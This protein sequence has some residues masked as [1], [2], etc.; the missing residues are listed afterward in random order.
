MAL[1]TGGDAIQAVY[2]IA[3]LNS[4]V[5]AG[6]LWRHRDRPGAAPLLANVL[7]AAVW[8]GTGL[9][10]M[11]L[12]SGPLARALFALM[13]LGIGFAT[14]TLLVFTLEYT[15][16]ER[17]TRP[18]ILAA[19]SIEPLL[20]ALFVVVNPDALF[21]TLH[22]GV[23]E[24]GPAFWI[25]TAYS[26][27]VLA[28]ATGL[29]GEFLYR[30]RSLYRGQS[31]ALLAGTVAA[32]VANG[33]YT[34]GP[35][36][37]DTTPIGFIAT[38][39]LYAIAIVRYRLTD[40]VPIA[41]DRVLDSV[42]DGVFVVDDDNRLIDANPVARSLLA[43][44]DGS[45]IGAT[46]DSL[47]ADW[48]ALCEEFRT[49]TAAGEPAE[50]ELEVDGEHYLVKTTPI[51][52]GRDRHVGWLFVVRDITERKRRE[53]ELQ[54]QNDRLERFA[55]LVSH[56]LRNPLNVADGYLDLAREADD[57]AAYLDEIERSHERMETIIEDVL[58]L[59]REGADV[60][61]PEPVAL[62]DIAERAWNGV[63]TGA[64]S[65]AIDA[66][67]TILA[68]PERTT[69]L[70]ENLFRNSLEHGAQRADGAGL[71]ITVGT[72]GDARDGSVA[73]FYVA[74]DGSGIPSS[75]RDRVFEGGYT[76]DEDGTGFGLAIV[77]E[78]A[79]AHDWTGTVTESDTGGARF[80]FRGVEPA[81][82]AISS[83]AD[84]ES[85]ASAGVT[86][87]SQP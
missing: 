18:T 57:N 44:V 79:T 56:D 81:A 36:E 53:A 64:A 4:V 40:V 58:A 8:T 70:L 29:I 39:A 67:V 65:I 87:S 28:V 61:E 38:G 15:G 68:D 10:L 77:A 21:Y 27:T 24:W 17:F 82:G 13:F 5:L 51:E 31:A 11:R 7:A 73:G 37:V 14:M 49:L 32:W 35:I 47:L 55:D 63:E 62:A 48:P 84:S 78:I 12:E 60:T 3:V 33:V 72:L 30:S 20:A 6:V 75:R 23:V 19:L 41:R 54:R 52:D 85:D 83:D 16:R 1:G 34:L 86:E 45:P 43:D 76:T 46:V 69:R 50:R 66:D 42:T 71:E 22:E 25:H 80:E 59:A 9:A 26:Y 74:D 2:V